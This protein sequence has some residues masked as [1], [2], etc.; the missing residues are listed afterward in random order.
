MYSFIFALHLLSCLLICFFFSSRRRHT[1]CALVTGVQTC[2]LP[3][4]LAEQAVANDG[5]QALA[6]VVDHPPDVADVVLPA[7]QKGLVDVALVQFRVADK[8][9][10]AALLPVFANPAFEAEDRKGVG[11]GKGGSVRVDL[12]GR[13]SIKKKTNDKKK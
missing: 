5:V 6:V 7:F 8:R 10:H 12:G 3:I 1:R 4:Y 13:S 2:A 11:E 9:D